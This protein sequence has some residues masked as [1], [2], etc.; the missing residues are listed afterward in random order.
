M[1]YVYDRACSLPAFLT[2]M[3]LRPSVLL[4]LALLGLSQCGLPKDSPSP[5]DTLPA[6]T[7][8][9]AG[10]AGCLLDGQPWTARVNT[11][12]IP[13][14]HPV[15]VMAIPFPT[16]PRPMSLSFQKNVDDES[17]T[18]NETMITLE[19]PDVSHPGLYVFDRSP[20]PLGLVVVT[21][22]PAYAL[23]SDR[24]QLP[25]Q[26]LYTGPTATGR[27]VVT[28]IDSAAHVISGTFEFTARSAES[29]RVVRVTEGR[30]DCPLP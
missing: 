9:G 4:L 7:Q 14:I 29:G 30:F 24:H 28:R 16:G 19:L 25:H 18:N 13:M 23:F 27:L 17:A 5:A 20:L 12:A 6:A 22:T 1:A 8:T 21:G 26:S 3:P 11:F 2:A 15:S 10:T